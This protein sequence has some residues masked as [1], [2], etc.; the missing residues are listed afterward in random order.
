MVGNGGKSGFPPFSRKLSRGMK[1]PAYQSHHHRRKEVGE[2]EITDL[3]Y[4]SKKTKQITIDRT[5]PAVEGQGSFSN[6]Y[7]TFIYG[8]G[9]TEKQKLRLFITAIVV[10]VEQANNNNIG[11]YMR[12]P[13]LDKSQK[14]SK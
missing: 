7:H 5:R 14:N 11:F 9:E 4:R 13:N 8:C 3:L 1:F 6:A 10:V 12:F 2:T